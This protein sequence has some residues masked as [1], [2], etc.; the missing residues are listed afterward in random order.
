MANEVKEYTAKDSTVR[1]RVSEGDETVMTPGG[2]RNVDKGEYVV[3]T[4][5]PNISDVLTAD[6][7]KSTDYKEV[8]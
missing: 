3:S 7:W 1:A 6:E 5:N 2:P 4:E 8:K